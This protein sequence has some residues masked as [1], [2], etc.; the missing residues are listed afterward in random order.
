VPCIY[1]AGNG[2][3]AVATITHNVLTHTGGAGAQYVIRVGNE[4][5][6]S[7]QYTYDGVVITDNRI[8]GFTTTG[9]CH[10]LFV[11]FN[12]NAVIARNYISNAGYGVVVK[13]TEGT[14]YTA[15]GV[16]YNVIYNCDIGIRVKGV[17]DVVV[18]NNTVYSPHALIVTGNVGGDESTGVVLKNNILSGTGGCLLQIGSETDLST[19][20]ASDYAANCLYVYAPG[21]YVKR[22]GVAYTYAGWVALGYD[23]GSINA[24]PLFTNLATGDLTL[25][26]GSPCI[27]AGTNLGDL[28]DD[29]LAP[30]STWPFV[31]VL[32]QDDY[33]PAWDIGAYLAS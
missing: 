8:T 26:T 27:D 30:S 15:G 2:Q 21:D 1:L 11:G 7:Y 28:Y 20:A 3:G 5:A 32:D 23:S 31:T 24:D 33:G 19:I 12:R 13:G 25:L 16:L 29:A 4:T 22:Q 10:A 18:A 17:D 14:D 9:G 6:N